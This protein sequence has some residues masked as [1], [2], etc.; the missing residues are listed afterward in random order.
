M[1]NKP[2]ALIESTGASRADQILWFS[3]TERPILLQPKL[4]ERIWMNEL[5]DKWLSICVDLVFE[6]YVC[7]CVCV[8]DKDR[9][10][11]KNKRPSS[12]I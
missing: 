12:T 8:L 11:E 5:T 2:P 4:V 1:G 6:L 7:V 9:G 3:R 10:G